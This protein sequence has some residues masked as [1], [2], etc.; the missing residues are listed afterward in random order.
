MC[1]TLKNA[2]NA[3]KGTTEIRIHEAFSDHQERLPAGSGHGGDSM[4]G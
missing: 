4:V 1:L 3:T 2:K